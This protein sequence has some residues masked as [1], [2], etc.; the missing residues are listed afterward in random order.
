MYNIQVVT[1]QSLT[2]LALQNTG[3]YDN[4]G[5]LAI[6][7]DVPLDYVSLGN[8]SLL[9]DEHMITNDVIAAYVRADSLANKVSTGQ[10]PEWLIIGDEDNTGIGYWQVDVDLVVS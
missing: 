9:A 3:L 5:W 2:D 7:N 6:T 8:A 10:L 1:H 4:A